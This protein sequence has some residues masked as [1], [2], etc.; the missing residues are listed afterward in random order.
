M[1]ATVFALVALIAGSALGYFITRQEFA[2]E[3]LPLEVTPTGISVPG[4]GRRRL[5]VRASAGSDA[6]GF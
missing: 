1:K 3:N 6:L 4:S 2:H 5:C